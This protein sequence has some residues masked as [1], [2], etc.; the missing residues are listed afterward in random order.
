MKGCVGQK[1]CSKGFSRDRRNS[2]LL[3]LPVPREEIR[4]LRGGQVGQPGEDVG[5]PGLRI[6]VIQLGRDDQGIHEGGAV[7]APL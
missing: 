6:G 2:G 7:S 3:S 1:P 4:H 5:Q